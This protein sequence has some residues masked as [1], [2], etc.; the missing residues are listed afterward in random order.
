[1]STRQ[2]IAVDHRISGLDEL[3]LRPKRQALFERLSETGSSC[4]MSHELHGAPEEQ[5]YHNNTKGISPV[6][7]SAQCWIDID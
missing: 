1:M 3:C 2:R 5:I 6:A 7:L 4:F